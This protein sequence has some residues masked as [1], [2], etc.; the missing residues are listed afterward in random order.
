MREAGHFHKDVATASAGASA[1]ELAEQMTREAVG[2]IVVVDEQS[3]P[4]GIVTD[5]DLALRVVAAGRSAKETSAEA[6]MSQP[7]ETVEAT[8]SVEGVIDRMRRSGIRRVPV[9]SDGRVV[10]IVSV[11]DLVVQLGQELDSLGDTLRHQIREARRSAH[12]DAI[13]EELR[14]RLG[15]LLEQ[16]ERAGGH[17]RETLLRELDSLRERLRRP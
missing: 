10:G 5:R 15:G 1:R 3:R 13:R 16:V 7:L 12:M 9:V 14:K 2:C 6:V 17:T 4:I 8:D 11:D